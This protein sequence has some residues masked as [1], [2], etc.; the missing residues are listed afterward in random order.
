M[1]QIVW[2]TRPD[3]WNIYFN[4]QWVDYTGLT[5]EES[6]GHGWNTPFHPD[7]KQRAW[8][9]WQRATQHDD[10]YSLECR[11]R[12]ADGVYRWWLIRGV[13]LRNASGEILKWFGTCTDIEDIK[14]AATALQASEEQHRLLLQYLPVGVVVHA[15]DTRVLLANEAATVLLGLSW[16]RC[17]AKWPWTRPGALSG[18][19]V[20]RYLVAE[21]PVS[22]VVAT[23]QPVSGH[24]PGY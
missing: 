24:T 11:L 10:A 6:Y 16:E 8:D 2:V 9:A 5:L 23:G 20:V 15:P 19:M 1:P 4:Q 17:R 21:Y 22:R 14:R 7:D 18:R 12:R 13:P 3:G